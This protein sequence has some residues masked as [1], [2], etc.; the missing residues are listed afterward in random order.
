[1]ANLG[2]LVV[3]LEA[4]IA[5][6]T[7]D[8]EA[9]AQQTQQATTRMSMGIN[10]VKGALGAL[11]AGVSIGAI[12]NMAKE[13]MDAADNLRDMSQKTGIA[14]ET[15]NG[16][17][18]AAGQAGGSLESVAEAAGK[19]NKSVVEAAGGNKDT[20]EAFNVLGISVRDA[21]GRLK[22]ADVVMAEV[23]DRFKKYADGPEKSAIALRIFGKA[24][25]DMIPLLND[26]GDAMR[27]NTE[28]AKKYSG[29]T[30]EL[31]NGSDN[32]NDSMGKLTVQQKNF[33]NVMTTAA[34]PVV[35][36]VVDELLKAAENSDKFSSSAGGLRRTLSDVAIAGA[37][38]VFTFSSVWREFAVWHKQAGAL[39]V[40][41]TDMAKGPA[42]IAAALA[43]AAVDGTMS[44]SNFSA[45]SDAYNKDSERARKEHDEFL[46][47][48][49]KSGEGTAPE[50]SGGEDDKPKPTAPT[51]RAKGDDP[52]K[53]LMDGRL[54]AIE[55][56]YAA[57]RDTASYHDKF[58]QALR[59]QD[60]VDLGTY[61]AYKLAAID[62]GAANA[63]RAYDAELAVLVKARASAAKQT[64]RADIDNKIR[65]VSAAKEKALRD[66]QEA[67]TLAVLDQ[68]GAQSRLNK[69]LGDWSLQQSQAMGQFQFEI[70]LYGKS[71]LEANK[72]TAA[73]RIYL[74]VEERIRQAQENSSTPINRAAFDAERDK[75]IAASN[76]LYDQADAK[77]SDP[78]FNMTESVRRYGEDASNTGAQIG[79][80]MRNSFQTA[81]DAFVQ[82]TT[83]GKLN[84][85]SMASS[86]IADF[87]RIEARKGMSSLLSM[88]MSALGS[89]F[90]A[91]AASAGNYTFTP[92]N[93]D[94][95][96]PFLDSIAGARATGGSVLGNSAYLVGE[97]GPEIFRP[98]GAG[99]ITPNNQ[100]G[101]GGGVTI[102][103]VTNIEAGSAD[104]QATGGANGQQR[105]AA[106]AL[107]AKMKQ[108]VMQES[109]QGGIIWNLA[110]GR[111]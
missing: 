36:T 20:S 3:S 63:R 107:N 73:R 57:E 64:D 98:T 68:S 104:T 28:Y 108:V 7:A 31:S 17:G 62:N 52:T 15:L 30:T 11:A 19:V 106:D 41:F 60:I 24:G 78:W 70:D 5:K 43:K 47:R 100:I 109:R 69:D 65:D 29:M 55:A 44:F 56:A 33:A 75:A 40:S 6:F 84:F 95:S 105:A 102:S 45:I 103:M 50:E 94:T 27:E 25:A 18:F 16:L 91:P 46:E 99:S 26:G 42:T 38:V 23:A 13:A 97:R 59:G 48:L 90:G 34:L 89:Y 93:L 49:A 76:A 77:Q 92:T 21:T 85:K 35:Q 54:K 39:G 4:N 82:F 81:E 12:V 71:T 22:T 80:A 88:G 67:R 58:M 61:E 10:L 53:A 66:A 9:A 86:I 51:L 74:D 83:T 79:N 72:L 87:A 14:V 110:Q 2:S 1:M 111:G 8:M 37:E 96:L 32:F 101:G